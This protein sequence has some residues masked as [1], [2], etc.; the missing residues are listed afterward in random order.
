MVSIAQLIWKYFVLIS[1]ILWTSLNQF[2]PTVCLM[3]HYYTQKFWPLHDDIL[4]KQSNDNDSSE[5]CL[6][7]GFLKQEV[8]TKVEKILDLWKNKKEQ[9]K[10]YKM[11]SYAPTY[12]IDYIFWG[13]PNK[14]K[15]C[16]YLFEERNFIWFGS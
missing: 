4:Q 5:S 6:N 10:C 14:Y 16:Y 8:A 15:S 7:I 9:T 13:V 11:I 12:E 1:V 3:I 2:L